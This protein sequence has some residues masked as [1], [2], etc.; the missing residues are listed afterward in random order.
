MNL[1]S[2][3]SFVTQ[4]NTGGI[5]AINAALQ[6]QAN[7]LGNVARNAVA[8]A[9]AAQRLNR[10]LSDQKNRIA[11]LNRL[12]AGGTM[13]RQGPVRNALGRFTTQ[14]Q[15]VQAYR[16]AVTFRDRINDVMR[17][18]G[19]VRVPNILAGL[20]AQL[21]AAPAAIATALAGVQRAILARLSFGAIGRAIAAQAQIGAAAIVR[22]LS[23][24]ART[25]AT[26]LRNSIGGALSALA[27]Q[28]QRLTSV[29]GGIRK[30]IAGAGIVGFLGLA[31]G[32]K[33]AAQVDQALAKI[34]TIA[35]TTKPL[36]DDIAFGLNRI[37]ATTGTTFADLSAASTTCCRPASA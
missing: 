20:Q 8:S 24:A 35:R 1:E 31:G 19:F 34:N 13:V 2:I 32:L 28:A 29:I 9:S 12:A 16:N 36:L 23:N 18:I 33:G 26:T 3:I 11:E 25:A 22:Q 17:S 7:A 21:Q 14:A 5:D 15:Y 10:A 30:V 37:S 27:S 4:A 6:T